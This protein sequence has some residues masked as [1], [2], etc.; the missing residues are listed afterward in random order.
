MIIDTAN[1]VSLISFLN[2]LNTALYT[3][4]QLFK[5]DITNVDKMNN[6]II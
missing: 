5:N 6:S 4:I 1:L 2:L 3:S